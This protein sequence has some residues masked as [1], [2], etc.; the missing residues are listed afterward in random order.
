MRRYYSHKIWFISFLLL[1]FSLGCCNSG[2]NP[3]LVPPTAISE[4]LRP[5][6]VAP[7]PIQ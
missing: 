5:V 2:A 4:T 3:V 1:I 7:V 6:R